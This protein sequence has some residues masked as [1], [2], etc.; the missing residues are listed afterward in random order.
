MYFGSFRKEACAHYD[1]CS[2]LRSS[3]HIYEVSKVGDVSIQTALD[4]GTLGGSKSSQWTTTDSTNFQPA[5]SDIDNATDKT[6]GLATSIPEERNALQTRW[7]ILKDIDLKAKVD[8]F[9]TDATDIF[10]TPYKTSY[11]QFEKDASDEL[12]GLK[13]KTNAILRI[14]R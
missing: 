5:Q 14:K 9:G 6:R 13:N 4:K 10:R 11:D 1:S 2:I 3:V 7:S 12:K 8:A